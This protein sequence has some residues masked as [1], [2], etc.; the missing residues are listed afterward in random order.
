M[1]IITRYTK[2]TLILK[3]WI[4]S[5]NI[6]FHDYCDENWTKN[7]NDCSSIVKYMFSMGVKAIL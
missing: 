1:K 3:L 7:T 4:N 2:D 5:E 6:N